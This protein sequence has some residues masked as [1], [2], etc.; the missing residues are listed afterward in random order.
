MN[1]RWTYYWWSIPFSKTTAQFFSE[2]KEVIYKKRKVKKDIV[3]LWEKYVLSIDEAAEYFGIGQ[4]RLRSIVASNP[5]AEYLITV[6]AKTLIKRKAFE[7]YID[8]A[9]VM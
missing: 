4:N 5:S 9:A 6:G 3:P 8:E 2:K 1:N 7:K